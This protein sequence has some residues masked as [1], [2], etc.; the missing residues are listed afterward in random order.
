MSDLINEIHQ[1][2]L[3]CIQYTRLAAVK[4]NDIKKKLNMEV[5]RLEAL[6]K[7]RDEELEEA[8]DLIQAL[9]A[10]IETLTKN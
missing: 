7:D 4:M 1:M 3:D 6:V 5:L 9:R 2:S 8:F 10:E